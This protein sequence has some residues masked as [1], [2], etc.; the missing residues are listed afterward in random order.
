MG[1]HQYRIHGHFDSGTATILEDSLIIAPPFFGVMDGVSGLYRPSEGPRFFY[2]MSGGQ[3][4][5]RPV[6]SEFLKEHA[7]EG[8]DDILHKAN[9]A[10]REF[11]EGTGLVLDRPD[12]LPGTQFVVAKVG[13]DAVE[14]MQCGDSLAVWAF[15]DGRVGA[16][17]NQTYAHERS[18]IAVLNDLLEKHHGDRDRVWEEYLPLTA[19]FRRARAN[20]G[21]TEGYVILNGQPEGERHWTRMTLAQ[22]ELSLL[23][24]FTDGLVTLEETN[25]PEGMAEL[26]LGRY[27]EGGWASAFKRIRDQE[28]QGKSMRHIDHAEAT[29]V[30]LE[31]IDSGAA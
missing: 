25:D 5:V 22:N 16:L 2:G 3:K 18:Q 28:E 27:R 13:D 15:S 29:A 30:A 6:A 24:M 7:G 23:L 14:V 19:S 11:A 12:I 17:R 9:S 31:F 1:T 21:G 20:S 8:L 4:V 10:I 26:V